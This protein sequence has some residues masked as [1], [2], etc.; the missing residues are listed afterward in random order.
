M[1]D[2]CKKNTGDRIQPS[3][4]PTGGQVPIHPTQ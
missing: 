1:R 3:R 2:Y 4:W